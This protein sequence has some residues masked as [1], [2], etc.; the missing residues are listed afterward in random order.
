[1]DA[2]L[3]LKMTR[4]FRGVH[5]HDFVADGLFLT[6]SRS[7]SSGYG[8]YYTLWREITDIESCLWL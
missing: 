1:M 2:F 4:K 8:N 6:L 5:A 7:I 3:L